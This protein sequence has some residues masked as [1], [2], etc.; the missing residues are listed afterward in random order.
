M[1]K[2]DLKNIPFICLNGKYFTYN[3]VRDILNPYLKNRV[4][5][6]EYLQ[7]LKEHDIDN[8][9]ALISFRTINK[10]LNGNDTLRAIAKRL[11]SSKYKSFLYD[12]GFTSGAIEVIKEYGRGGEWDFT[13]E[14]EQEQ[15]ITMSSVASMNW[16]DNNAL[17]C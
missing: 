5:K 12:H 13:I 14:I 10:S 15:K 8:Q 7:F 9:I 17:A 16:F 6:P 11:A 1:N 4:K 2:E 3:E